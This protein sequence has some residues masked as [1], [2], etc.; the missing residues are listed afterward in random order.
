M[1]IRDGSGAGRRSGFSRD[2]NKTLRPT[3]K[4][5]QPRRGMVDLCVHIQHRW[6]PGGSR[7]RSGFSRDF[8]KTLHPTQKTLR[9]RRGML[10]LCMH[11]QHCWFPGGSRGRSGFSRDFNKNPRPKQKNATATA[12]NAGFVCAYSAWLV[13]RWKSRL[14]PLLRWH[15]G[16]AGG[17]SGFSRDFNGNYASGRRRWPP[18][19]RL[20]ARIC[21]RMVWMLLC[22]WSAICLSSMP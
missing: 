5:L 8:N 17:R 4:T 1:E 18:R 11:I 16:G 15:A 21:T 19:L 10:D 9:P 12:R 6:F 20:M 7:G 2:F 14:K 22:R 3:Q 13:S